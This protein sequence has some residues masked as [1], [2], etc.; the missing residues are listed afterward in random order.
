M[1]DKSAAELVAGLRR[2]GEPRG[3]DWKGFFKIVVYA[4]LLY[5][6]APSRREVGALLLWLMLVPLCMLNVMGTHVMKE[7]AAKHNKQA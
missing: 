4:L 2:K 5:K 7:L 6:T 1:G 3:F